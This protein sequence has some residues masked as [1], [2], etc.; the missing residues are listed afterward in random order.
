MAS[1]SSCWRYWYG[2]SKP[3][4]IVPYLPISERIEFHKTLDSTNSQAMR[5]WQRQFAKP[6]PARAN[7]TDLLALFVTDTQTCGRG[8]QGRIWH[9]PAADDLYCSFAVRLDQHV[10]LDGLSLMIALA[11]RRA[12]E[13]ITGL[14]LG[15]KWP[16]DLYGEHH[17]LGGILIECQQQSSWCLTIGIGINVN[18]I[19]NEQWSSLRQELGGPVCRVRLLAGITA[20]LWDYLQRYLAFSWH[21]F[22]R[23][24][25]GADFLLNRK[26]SWQREQLH[27]GYA[28]GV[29]DKGLLRV[30][31]E[32]G[33]TH[34]LNSGEVHLM[35]IA[36]NTLAQSKNH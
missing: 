31:D 2:A 1:Q 21:D 17:K 34:E 20:T 14:R 28:C 25:Q 4:L 32:H 7:S 8:R 29:T 12:I 6:V 9:S 30:K 18:R 16:N 10:S 36:T 23:E 11:V 13:S 26:V 19:G 22:I 5:W 33:V 27:S 15:V 35:V 3:W 24:W